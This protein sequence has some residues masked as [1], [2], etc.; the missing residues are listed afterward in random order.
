MV[1]NQILTRFHNDI[2]NL[3]DFIVWKIAS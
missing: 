3:A 2:D 1:L